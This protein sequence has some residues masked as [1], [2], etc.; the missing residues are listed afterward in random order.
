MSKARREAWIRSVETWSADRVQ[1][2]LRR[3]DTP[4][5]DALGVLVCRR[6][7]AAARA[8]LDAYEC[9]EAWLG[10][11]FATAQALRN[12]FKHL[13]SGSPRIDTGNRDR[14]AIG[15]R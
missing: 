1:E 14:G 7:P 6:N 4:A 10:F 15:L 11:K 8:A 12:G 5:Q 3:R 9:Q 13:E 2:E